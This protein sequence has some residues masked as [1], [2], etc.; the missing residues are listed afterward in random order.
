VPEV[1][2]AIRQWTEEKGI[3]AVIWVDLPSNFE[4][5]TGMPLNDDNAIA[6][7]RSLTGESLEKAEEYVRKAPPQVRTTIRGRI[8]RELDWN[9]TQNSKKEAGSLLELRKFCKAC[10]QEKDMAEI[11][12]NPQGETIRLSCGHRII[13]VEFAETLGLSEQIMAKHF[14]PEHELKSRYKTKIS[15]KT[16][17]PARDNI[18]I[19]RDRKRIIHQV[20]E[21]NQNGEWDLVHDEEKPIYP[22]AN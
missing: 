22:E 13:S 8:E 17:R 3:D 6:Y 11:E 21:Q 9:Q 12:S 16:K 5:K 2:E 18:I 1:Y 19:D 14:G 4:D 20:W 15:E 10:N 7:L